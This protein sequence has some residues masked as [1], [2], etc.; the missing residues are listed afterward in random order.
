MK[1]E[2]IE[3]CKCC[4]ASMKSFYHTLSPGI[5]SGLIRAIQFVHTNKKNQ[6]HLQKDLTNLTKNEYNN[7]QKL[8]FHGLIAHVPNKSGYWLIT[9]RGGQFL[10]GEIAIPDQVQTFRNNVIGHSEGRIHINQLKNKVPDFQKE[11]A[12]EYEQ[13]E[14]P[15]QSTLL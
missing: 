8:R 12:Y 4:G 5:V 9:K 11:F 1:N 6:F 10:R 13:V 7:F 2:P 3:R 14:L 15:I